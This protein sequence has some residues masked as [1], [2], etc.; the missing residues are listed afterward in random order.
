MEHA[1]FNDYSV[2]LV[3]TAILGFMLFGASVTI[4]S[5]YRKGGVKSRLL[6]SAVLLFLG[7]AVIAG[8]ACMINRTLSTSKILNQALESNET[9]Q[10]LLEEAGTRNARGAADEAE[11][12]DA[13]L[14][15]PCLI[16]GYEEEGNKLVLIAPS[17]GRLT[18][19]AFEEAGTIVLAYPYVIGRQ[20]YQRTVN[21]AKSNT[22]S[23]TR[24][25]VSIYFYDAESRE[26]A[27]YT[28][29]AAPDFP[30]DG[31]SYHGRVYLSEIK[32]AVKAAGNR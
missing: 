27:L 30:E 19:K 5:E 2:W 13:A 12:R 8:G 23:E 11:N 15:S 32:D 10:R 28:K 9:V 1:F 22:Y 29:L 24:Y 4:F 14:K 18:A 31:K 26:L 17:P 7:A 21:G 6:G 16:L 25:G 3:I 20:L